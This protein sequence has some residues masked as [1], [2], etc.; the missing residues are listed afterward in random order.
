MATSKLTI[1]K[2]NITPS[3]NF[4][5]DSI[6]TYL[7]TCKKIEFNKFQYQQLELNLYVKIPLAQE[8]I[9]NPQYNYARLEQDNKE[10]YFF[11]M[12]ADWKARKTIGLALS[13]DTINTYWSQ[14]K[15]SAKTAIQR[16]HRDRWQKS[17]SNY[18]RLIDRYQEGLNPVKDNVIMSRELA[19]P[20]YHEGYLVWLANKGIT[21]DVQS[22]TPIIPCYCKRDSFTFEAEQDYGSTKIEDTIIQLQGITGNNTGVYYLTTTNSDAS[23]SNGFRCGV[24]IGGVPIDTLTLLKDDSG[25]KLRCIRMVITRNGVIFT[26]QFT[27]YYYTGDVYPYVYNKTYTPTDT[28]NIAEISLEGNIDVLTYSSIISDY[29]KN[30]TSLDTIDS[31][32]QAAVHVGLIPAKVCAS[33]SDLDRSSTNIVKILKVPFELKDNARGDT[34]VPGWNLI[35]INTK[36]AEYLPIQLGNSSF[37][38]EHYLY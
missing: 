35:R 3:R 8:F 2:T 1:Y 19:I 24:K 28:Y 22:A 21:P 20:E 32:N 31:L 14:V 17:G 33:F 10:F 30:L 27:A 16:E 13:M 5:V 12:S 36:D 34:F 7:N 4:R 11:I 26:V 15:W 23:S 6:D 38:C 37:D 18:K 29:Y 25:A 9:S